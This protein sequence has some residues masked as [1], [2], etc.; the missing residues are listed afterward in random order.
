LVA[1]PVAAAPNQEREPP[2]DPLDKVGE[3]LHFASHIAHPTHFTLPENA[4]SAW[5]AEPVTIAVQEE[6]PF[7]FRNAGGALCAD[8][9]ATA[10]RCS[11]VSRSI[12]EVNFVGAAG[13]EL[14]SLTGPNYSTTSTTFPL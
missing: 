9:I 5:R 11:A 2:F 13:T 6:I 1:N 8:E 7:N 4:P 10:V 12:S 3:V 14:S